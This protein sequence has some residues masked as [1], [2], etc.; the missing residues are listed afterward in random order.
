MAAQKTDLTTKL[1]ISVATG[2]KPSGDAITAT[3]TVGHINPEL[4]DADMLDIGTGLGALQKYEVEA[5]KRI[6]SAVLV[7]E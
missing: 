3:R 7:D 2:L 1:S 6:D 4:T 5:V